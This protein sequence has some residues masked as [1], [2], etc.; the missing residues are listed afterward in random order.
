MIYDV[1]NL[2]EERQ[3]VD[4]SHLKGQGTALILT[5]LRENVLAPQATTRLYAVTWKD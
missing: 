2:S 1:K 3:A 4:S 5:A